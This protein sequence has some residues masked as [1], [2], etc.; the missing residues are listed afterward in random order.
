MRARVIRNDSKGSDG[1]P[2]YRTI[3]VRYDVCTAAVSRYDD[4]RADVTRAHF[5]V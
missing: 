3:K 4:V 5:P 2:K 1:V